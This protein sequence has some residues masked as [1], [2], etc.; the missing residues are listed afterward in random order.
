V[1]LPEPD[2]SHQIPTG[3]EG[4]ARGKVKSRPKKR[5]IAEK[6]GGGISDVE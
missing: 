2:K 5:F 4:R 1:S 3:G 6:I